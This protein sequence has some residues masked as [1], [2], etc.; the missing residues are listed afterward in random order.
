MFI[1]GTA[2]LLSSKEVIPEV[3]EELICKQERRL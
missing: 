2:T 1:I 3:H